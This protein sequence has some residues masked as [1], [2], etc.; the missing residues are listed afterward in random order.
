MICT[1]LYCVKSVPLDIWLVERCVCFWPSCLSGA[2]SSFTFSSMCAC[3]SLSDSCFWSVLC[4]CQIFFNNI[5]SP[6]FC[7]L[8]LKILS[9][10]SESCIFGLEHVLIKVLSPL[11]NGMLHYQYAVTALKLIL[12]RKFSVSV[13]K[14]QKCIWY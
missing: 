14:N 6:S 4:V 8:S 13:Y 7:S 3:V 10:S 12:K 2:T 11:L 9:V 1:M 5:P